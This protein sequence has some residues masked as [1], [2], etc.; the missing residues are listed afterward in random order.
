ME[1]PPP[2]PPAHGGNFHSNPAGWTDQPQNYVPW[3]YNPGVY[4]NPFA[5]QRPPQNPTGF[6][7][8]SFTPLQGLGSST[9]HSPM[10]A[11][12]TQIPPD[13]LG[14][15]QQNATPIASSPGSQGVNH[16]YAGAYDGFGNQSGWTGQMDSGYRGLPLQPPAP[17][18][19]NARHHAGGNSAA[20]RSNSLPRLQTTLAPSSA[21]ARSQ[22]PQRSAST[23]SPSAAPFTPGQARYNGTQQPSTPAQNSRGSH[24][25]RAPSYSKF[26]SLRLTARPNSGDACLCRR[27]LCRPLPETMLH[28]ANIITC[29]NAH[30][31]ATSTSTSTTPFALAIT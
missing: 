3:F 8:P 10:V 6:P 19:G 9:N 21:G 31:S 14:T 18:V 22:P 4:S 28:I 23:F 1:G 30:P 15:W 13:A 29:A 16:I 27:R 11:D 24:L 2:G 12:T 17:V 5:S 26:I 25:T 7:Q 20:A